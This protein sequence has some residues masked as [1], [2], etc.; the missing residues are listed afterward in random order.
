MHQTEKMN[1]GMKELLGFIILALVF[2]TWLLCS[3]D[4]DGEEKIEKQH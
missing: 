1:L 2:G 4:E 3:G